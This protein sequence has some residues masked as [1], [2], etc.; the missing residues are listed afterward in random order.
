MTM[1]KLSDKDREALTAYLDGELDEVTARRVETRLNLDPKTRLE[2][3]AL[4][5]AWNMLDYLPRA[6][7]SATFTHRTLERLALQTGK[8]PKRGW[9][10]WAPGLAWAAAVMVAAAA[11]FGAAALIW[12]QPAPLAQPAEIHDLEDQ[13]VRHLRVIEKLQLYEHVD[14]L[15]FLRGLDQPELFGNEPGS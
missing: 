10:A 5:Q 11:G 12:R 13:M 14:D 2:A 9:R 15:D 3:E 1:A 7:P 8:V 4:K 6:E